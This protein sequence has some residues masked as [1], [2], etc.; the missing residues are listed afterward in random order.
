MNAGDERG[1]YD[2]REGDDQE[3]LGTRA[4]QASFARFDR[5]VE[6]ADAMQIRPGTSLAGDRDATPY[7]SVPDQVR[8][9]VAVALDH[10]HGMKLTVVGAKAVIPFGMFTAM[11]SAYEASATGLWLLS[12]ESR[13]ERVLRSLRLGYDNRR[14]V[15][16]ALEA[17]GRDDPGFNRAVG[18]LERD[19]DGRP[20]LNGVDLRGVASVTDRLKSIAELLPDLFMPP[21]VLWQTSSGM[22]HGNAAMMLQLLDREQMTDVQHGGADY[23]LTPS[24]LTLAS[25]F[26][27][28]LDMIEALCDLYDTRNQGRGV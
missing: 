10:L 9:A 16:N 7:S 15:K 28:A 21:L 8:T 4:L 23:M 1:R 3:Q 24:L 18:F 25:Y 17:L 26:D 13:D 22:A 11:R 14:Q 27:A 5:L 6:R 12:P 20:N 19:R 2:R